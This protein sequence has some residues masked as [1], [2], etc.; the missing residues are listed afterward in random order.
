MTQDLS[1]FIPEIWSKKLSVLL[2]K[3]GVMMQCINR[4]YEGEIKNSGDTVHIR[5]YG[6]VT[7]KTYSGS[8]TYDDL[9][10]PL[11]DLTI[12][13]K[14]YFAFKVDDVSKAQ[15][16][17]DIMAGYLQRAKVA[18]DLAKDTFLLAKHVDVPSGNTVGTESVPIALTKDNIYTNFVTIAKLLKK[19]NA[20][21]KDG[22]SPFIIINPDIEAL[23]VQA[24]EF[25]Q[26]NQIGDKVIREGSIGRIAGLDVL[27]CTNFE[28]VGGKLYI[29][30]GTNDAITFASQVVEVE[31]IRLQDSFDTA[32]RGLYVYGAKTVATNA[33]AKIIATVAS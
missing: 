6:S 29:M 32:V 22:K 11:Q 24:P 16:N 9:T 28:A 15:S 23:L 2:D 18:I 3:S 10:S 13:Q 5:T 14:K 25:I 20:V 17:I 33:L 21:K 4:D 7:V 27:V 31:S 19:A 30:A 12:D 26:A 1:N 8:I